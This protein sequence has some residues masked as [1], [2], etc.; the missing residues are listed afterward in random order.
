MKRE[1]LSLLR[2]AAVSDPYNYEL[3][4]LALPL[5][6]ELNDLEALR[7]TCAGV[8]SKAWPAKY[9]R[10]AEEARLAARATSLRLKK[11]GRVVEATAFENEIK[12][13]LRRDIVV[14]VTWT[15]DADIALRVKEPVGTICSYSNPQTLS[16][17]ILLDSASMR[18]GK[19]SMDGTSEYY[20]CAQGYAGEYDIL[21]R[22]IFGKVA[23]GKATVEIL[24]DYGT[25][26][27]R[28]IVQQVD[29]NSKDALIQV[30]VKNGHRK[31]PMA[32]A[33]LATVRQRQL[34]LGRSILAQ[35]AADS[36]GSSS[37]GS[38]PG[39][40]NPYAAMQALLSAGAMNNGFPFRGA[41]GYRPVI[42]TIPEGAN[43]F[44]TGVVSA[45]RR[46]VRVAPMPFF[47]QIGE[48]FTFNFVSGTTGGGTGTTGGTGAQSGTGGG[49]GNGGG[50]GVF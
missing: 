1:A 11:E 33:D 43:M 10:L 36:S 29:I 18:S 23:G 20:V 46:Y 2:D 38:A 19:D 34:T 41:V 12:E 16:G 14:R 7:W 40:Y 6:R 35:A 31:E 9:D 42:Q 45:D 37:S 30:A 28:S 22:R 25:P 5:A 17:G 50:G 4:T 3:F 13:A 27:Q 32:A 48:V 47:S 49:F 44:V 26:E 24:T 15:G 39:A 21:L 8:L